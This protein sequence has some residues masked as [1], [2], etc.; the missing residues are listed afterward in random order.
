ML[1]RLKKLPLLGKALAVGERRAGELAAKLLADEKVS[2]GLQTAFAAA[3]AAKRQ[4][5]QRL[6]RTLQS[7]NLASAEELRELRARL[8]EMERT[9]DELS[10]KRGSDRD[11]GTGGGA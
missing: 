2:A 4:L 9:V 8:A 10:K 3:Q 5:E 11:G 6:Q 1:D 7:W